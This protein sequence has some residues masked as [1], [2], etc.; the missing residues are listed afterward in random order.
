MN[1]RR[2]TTC[3]AGVTFDAADEVE[4]TER[5]AETWEDGLEDRKDGS[6]CEEDR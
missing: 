1:W 4:T 2:M 3:S 6:K 5:E